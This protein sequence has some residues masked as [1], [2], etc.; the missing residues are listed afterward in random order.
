MPGSGYYG[1][2][3]DVMMF[4]PIGAHNDGLAIAT[5]QTITIPAG[6]TKFLVQALGQ[7][8]RITLDG[9]PPTASTGF[10]I[11]ADDPWVLVPL[12]LNTSI[13]V[14]EEAATAD[15]QYQFGM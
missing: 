5:A 1:D 8:V 9:T 7:N 15:L 14:I 13:K 10:Q 2:P 6:A 3:E 11:K 4:D 12:G